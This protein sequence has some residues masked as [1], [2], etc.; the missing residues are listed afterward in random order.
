MTATYLAPALVARWQDNNNNPLV[1]GTVTTY[2]GGTNTPIATWTDSTGITANANPI[3]L[4]FRG[5][6]SIWLL[7]NV[8]YKFVVADSLG[9]QITVVD[10]V[11]NAALVSLFGGTD[12][13]TANAYI[14]NFASP[15]PANTN[16]QVV[17]WL[18]ANSNTGPSTINVNGGG[19]QP[20]LNPNGTAL[21]ANQLLANQYASIIEINGVWQLYGGSGV[22]VNVGTFG[23]EFVIASAATTDLGSAPGHNVSITGTASITS[24]GTSAQL[25]APIYIGRFTQSCTLT[26]STSLVLPSG[27]NIST[28]NGDS[29]IAEYMGSGN[30]RVLHYQQIQ[31]NF[32]FSKVKPSDTAI[33]SSTA[34]TA[35]PAL[36]SNVL[37]PGQYEIEVYLLFDAVAAGAGFKWEL[38]G[39]ATDLR[40]TI[41]MIGIGF[42]NGSF[43]SNNGSPYSNVLSYATLATTANSNQLLYRGS[44]LV[45]AA[46]TVGIQ[47]A[48]NVSTASAVTLRAGSY[49]TITP[50]GNGASSNATTHIYTSGSGSEVIPNGV[51][52]CVIEVAGAGGS[53]GLHFLS[54]GSGSGGGGGGSGGYCRSTVSV[55]SSGGLTM[56][57]S[58]GAATPLNQNGAPSTVSSGTFTL[59]TLTGGGGILGGTAPGLSAGGTG[60]AGGT[61]FGGANA[62]ISGNAGSAG[63]NTAGGGAGGAGGAGVPGVNIGGNPGGNGGIGQTLGAPTGGGAGVVAFIYS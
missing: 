20:I 23:Q 8:A 50:I 19:P 63:V 58:V 30:W 60:G 7:P 36:V 41:P 17:F 32:G 26:T 21:G 28:Q 6:A 35:D 18:P 47:W 52:S 55:G 61:A 42:V 27:L 53:G 37:S 5:E 44:M 14:L 33:T 51:T 59:T 25:V 49:L 46:G 15:V 45:N 39:T 56:A 62:N 34:L 10:N 24:F 16:G 1:G 2:A 13:G 4:N 11:V 40:A 22:G 31:P 12:T 48:Q 29:F 9:N 38:N 3:T 57:Y 43:L 54:G